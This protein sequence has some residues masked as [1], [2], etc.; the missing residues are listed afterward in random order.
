MSGKE[1][2]LCASFD[3]A[4][5]EKAWVA[6][7]ARQEKVWVLAGAGQRKNLFRHEAM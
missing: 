4:G 7:R 2:V 3:G 5:Q 1:F 6:D